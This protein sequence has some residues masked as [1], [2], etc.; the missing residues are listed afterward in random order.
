MIQELKFLDNISKAIKGFPQ[1]IATEAV[2][3]SKDRFVSQNWVDINTEQWAKRTIKRRSKKRE[4]GAVLVSSGRLKRS[5]RK[6]LVT[7]DVVVIGTD[8]PYA[9]IHNNGFRGRE[10][11]KMHNRKSR[12][13]KSFKVNSFSRK[14]NMPR[15][16]FIG[17]SNVLNKKL[18]AI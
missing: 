18:N 4:R 1:L 10:S 11:V 5:I 14:M 8:V 17:E 16:R 2:N 7:N 9:S 13:G 12:K 6:I 3:F 15:R